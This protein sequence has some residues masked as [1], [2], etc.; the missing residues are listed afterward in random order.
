[1]K[2]MRRG[3]GAVLAVVIAALTVFAQPIEARAESTPTRLVIVLDAG[4]GGTDGGATRTWG[5]KRYKE[6]QLNLKIAKYCKQELE[7]YVGV[8][9]YLTRE[10]DTYVSLEN[11]VKYAKSV[12]ADLFV[13]L[14][15]NAAYSSAGN[16]ACVFYPN[17]NYSKAISNEGRLA[18]Q[19]IEDA[20]VS[21]G[22]KNRGIA[23]RN[24][25]TNTRYPD[26]KLADYYQVI[27]LSKLCGFPGLI[28][29]HAYVSSPSDCSR[30]LG[31]DAKLKRLGVA[32]A[33]GIAQA[34][35]LVKG[36][37][38][39][40]KSAKCRSDGSVVLKWAKS[41]G[42]EGYAVYR[43]VQ[44]MTNET[45]IATLKGKSTTTYTDTAAPGGGTY[46]YL[47]RAYADG[48]ARYCTDASNAL[49]VTVLAAP[50]SVGMTTA[51]SG[52]TQL[53]I[54][55]VDGAEGYLIARSDGG[56]YTLAADLGAETL[57]WEDTAAEEGRAYGYKVCAYVVRDGVQVKSAY[58]AAVMDTIEETQETQDTE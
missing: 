36:K 29:E 30:F 43:R 34:Y 45:L 19:S 37:T 26:K 11:R 56:S 46:E 21:L 17:R 58:T 7:K 14:H 39:V 51:E 42:A 18:A 53:V 28:V 20:L 3:I 9:V 2:M 38:P 6:K 44:G 41:T 15:N 54:A 1:M 22:L 32:D 50:A 57:V 10:D 23:Y 52:L 24:S 33:T 8:K 5:G 13:S 40:L 49:A 31:T 12:G 55:P 4:H 16:G 35:G 48:K 25:E 47:I 27:K